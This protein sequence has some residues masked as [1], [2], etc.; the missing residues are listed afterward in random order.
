M[1]YGDI[2]LVLPEFV[3]DI[4]QKMEVVFIKNADLMDLNLYLEEHK[5]GSLLVFKKNLWL[6]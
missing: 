3:F 5:A 4:S 1:K 2:I 6:L